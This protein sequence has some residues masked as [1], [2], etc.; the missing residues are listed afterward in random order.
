MV[1][2]ISRFSLKQTGIKKQTARVIQFIWNLAICF[3]CEW[4]S[5]QY[6]M[7]S[8]WNPTCADPGFDST[9][10]QSNY[11]RIK[12]NTVIRVTMFVIACS[13]GI[14]E[15]TLCCTIC[16]KSTPEQMQNIR[17][18]STRISIWLQCTYSLITVQIPQI[19]ARHIELLQYPTYSASHIFIFENT[20][21]KRKRKK[22]GS[23][24]CLSI[25][26][27]VTQYVI[28]KSNI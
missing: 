16:S 18:C 9:P 21:S 5:K 14:W 10:A 3:E 28:M 17:N 12:F 8:S 20:S 4:W 19:F 25:F 15:A 24:V 1:E 6:A 13:C 23:Y 26:Y 22:M 7:Y 11:I 27:V 2:W